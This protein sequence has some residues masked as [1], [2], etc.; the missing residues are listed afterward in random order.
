ME[1]IVL[2]KPPPLDREAIWGDGS[3]A[4]RYHAELAPGID[5]DN[6]HLTGG[7][8]FNEIDFID[9]GEFKG[10]TLKWLYDNHKEYFGTPEEIR[11]QDMLPLSAG[12]LNAGEN[13]SVQVHPREDWAME[14]LGIH[15]KSECWYIID[16]PED[17]T[18]VRGHNAKTFQELDDYIARKD[19]KGLMHEDPI[20]P[21]DLLAIKAGTLHAIKKGTQCIEVCNP[22]PITYRFWDWDRLG[23][24]GKPRPLDIEKTRDNILVPF[25]PITF[26]PIVEQ[27]DGVEEKWLANNEDYAVCILTVDGKGTV[28]RKKPFLGCFVVD[29]EGTVNGVPVKAGRP[30]LVT[31]GCDALELEGKMTVLTAHA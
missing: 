20:K 16:C 29:G 27:H 13:L 25:R 4:R 5:P 24:D 12:T 18:V 1:Q 31:R 2:L 19:W 21:G 8:G 15:G 3:L 28:P 26:P 6:N 22:C 10:Q 17:A 30:F 9:S 7:G 11:W 14:H 23:L